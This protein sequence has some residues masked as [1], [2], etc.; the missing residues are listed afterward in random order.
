MNHASASIA[1][2][3]THL[4]SIPPKTDTHELKTSHS[5]ALG[6]NGIG[7]DSPLCHA[8]TVSALTDML[9]ALR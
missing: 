4:A 7:W 1:Y 9:V 2:R 3:D 8:D 6:G 5:A